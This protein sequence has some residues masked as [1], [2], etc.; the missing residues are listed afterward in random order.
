MIEDLTYG[1]P[2]FASDVGFPKFA[3]GVASGF[4]PMPTSFMKVPD[5]PK[6]NPVDLVSLNV[7]APNPMFHEK[8]PLK[9]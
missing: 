1:Q 3:A 6:E 2:G 7:G 9:T 4:G 5:L 8:I